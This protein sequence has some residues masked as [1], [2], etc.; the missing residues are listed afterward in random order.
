M[1]VALRPIQLLG[2]EFEEMAAV[3]DPGKAI[4]AGQRP[5][6]V[7]ELLAARDLLVE[8]AGALLDGLLQPSRAL[9]DVARHGLEDAGDRPAP[10]R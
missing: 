5:Q 2:A 7:L 4:D 6:L 3:V 8:V 9:G 10:R 1:V